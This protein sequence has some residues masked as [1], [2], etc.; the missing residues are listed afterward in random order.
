[1][2]TISTDQLCNVTGGNWL[3]SLLG[4]KKLEAGTPNLFAPSGEP[5]SRKP[6]LGA[7]IFGGPGSKGIGRIFGFN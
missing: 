4:Q 6:T 2:K 5:Q 3:Q 1:M 7:S